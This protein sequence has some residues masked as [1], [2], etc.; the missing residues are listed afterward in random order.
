LLLPFKRR[1][2]GACALAAITLWSACSP[3][4]PTVR[5]DEAF[6]LEPGETAT[7]EG[8]PV[9][10]RFVLVLSDSRCPADAV[11]VHAGDAVVR[12]EVRSAGTS[13]PYELHTADMRPVTHDDLTIALLELAP[14]PFSS[15]PIRPNEY[16]ATFKV[17]G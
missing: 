15:R 16:R 9:R 11:C 5:P 17:T 3:T 10:I 13:R 7:V 12:I 8:T 6:T 2:A 4:A 1:A 14:Y